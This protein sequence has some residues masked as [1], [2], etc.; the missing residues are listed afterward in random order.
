MPMTDTARLAMLQ[1]VADRE[2]WYT[3]GRGVL[4]TSTGR[5]VLAEATRL[6][7]RERLVDVDFDAERLGSYPY[8]LTPAGQAKLDAGRPPGTNVRK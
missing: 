6:R 5:D 4:N 2:V 7:R 3:P 1:A 8:V